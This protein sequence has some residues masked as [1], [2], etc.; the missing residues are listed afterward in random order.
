M[1]GKALTNIEEL[2]EQYDNFVF[3]CD[4]VVWSGTSQIGDAFKVIEW[5]ETEKK[6]NVY[7]VTNNASKTSQELADKMASMGY[8]IPKTDRMYATARV[9][10]GFLKHQYPHVKKVFAIGV[11]SLRLELEAM[12]FEVLGADQDIYG[13]FEILSPE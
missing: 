12:G 2:A 9:A 4:G 7:F 8:K 1:E 11:K 5:L 3:D 6:K 13:K 10:S